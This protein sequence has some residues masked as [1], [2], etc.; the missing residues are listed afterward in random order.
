[1]TTVEGGDSL[2][3]KGSDE[4]V[5]WQCFW[6]WNPQ[7]LVT[8]HWYPCQPFLLGQLI[9]DNEDAVSDCAHGHSIMGKQ[10]NGLLEKLASW[11]Q[12][13]MAHGIFRS[14]GG[15]LVLGSPPC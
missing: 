10:V 6:P 4:S 9:T 11:A 7:S 15:E 14:F 2:S 1:M 8:L 13:F 5:P 3:E 12:I